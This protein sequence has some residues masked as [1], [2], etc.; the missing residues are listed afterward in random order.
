[1]ANLNSPQIISDLATTQHTKYTF[2]LETPYGLAIQIDHHTDDKALTIS[3]KDVSSRLSSDSQSPSTTTTDQET[4]TP[5]YKY[6]LFPDWGAGFLCAWHN[7]YEKWVDHYT[8]A[9]GKQGCDCGSKEHPFPD[10][11]ERK[12]WVLDGMMLAVWLTLQPG[13][14]SVEYEPS[15]KKLVFLKQGLESIVTQFLEEL[16]QY[17][18]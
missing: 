8:E 9:F 6:R 17:L 4:T 11:G 12:A 7:A 13:V 1:M 5:S 14:E 2:T 16:E 18:T 3:L 15:A 10:I